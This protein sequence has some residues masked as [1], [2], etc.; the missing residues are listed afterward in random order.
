[1][2]APKAAGLVAA[3]QV[4]G[5]A[6]VAVVPARR[7]ARPPARRRPPTRPPELKRIRTK[8]A[9]LAYASKTD[10][11]SGARSTRNTDGEGR[12]A[13]AQSPDRKGLSGRGCRDS[14]GLSKPAL[15]A[16][17]GPRPPGGSI[18]ARGLSRSACLLVHRVNAAHGRSRDLKGLAGSRSPVGSPATRV[19][20][21]M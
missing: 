11:L 6:A 14:E 17:C 16:R 18:A 7:H 15:D 2:R 13:A 21:P 1:M 5:R 4:P 3:A 8:P 19:T 9:R 10:A 12:S 20:C